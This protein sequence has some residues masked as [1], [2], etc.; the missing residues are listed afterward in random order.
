MFVQI[1][2]VLAIL[3]SFWR[4]RRITNALAKATPDHEYSFDWR[5]STFK[6]KASLVLSKIRLREFPGGLSKSSTAQIR[7]KNG[8][9]VSSTRVGSIYIYVYIY[10]YIHI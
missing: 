4:A 1:E 9:G 8:S 6:N 5:A 2:P 7:K 10:I 3:S